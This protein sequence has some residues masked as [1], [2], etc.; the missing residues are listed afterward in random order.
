V[1]ERSVD[2]I[3]ERRFAADPSGARLNLEADIAAYVDRPNS[4][5]FM[6]D[7]IVRFEGTNVVVHTREHGEG[8][9]E[10]M[11]PLSVTFSSSGRRVCMVDGR[12]MAVDEDSYLL[13]NLGQYVAGTPEVDPQ[14]E[15]FLIG[16][17]PGFAEDVLRTIVTPADRLLDNIKLARFQPVEFFPQLYRHDEIVTPV[18]EELRCAVHSGEMTHGWLEEWNH[19]LLHRLLFAHRVVVKDIETL[20]AV[21]AATRAEYYQRLNRARDFM[22]SHLDAPLDLRRISAEAFL[23]PHHFLRLFKQ[24]FKETPHQY[25]TRRRIERAQRLLLRTEMPVTDVC[26]AVGFESLGSFSWLFKKRTGLSPEQYRKANA[27]SR[28]L[29]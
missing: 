3:R 6:D 23:S 12:R 11:G 18:L 20:P 9:R 4:L 26:F 10:H 1:K 24:V 21:K 27:V 29:R 15:S 19:R 16:F 28:Y 5:L 2:D 17:W 22:E 7:G 8:Y 13:S 14:G 25:L